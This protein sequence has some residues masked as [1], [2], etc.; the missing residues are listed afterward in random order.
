MAYHASHYVTLLLDQ[1]PKILSLI[2]DPFGWGWNLFG[3]TNK[4]R[5]AYLPDLTWVWHV[6]VTLI[7]AG[8]V[9]SVVLAHRVALRVFG[10]RREAILS[11]LPMLLLMVGF[12]VFGLWIL[13]QPLTAMVIR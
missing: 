13:A 8:H 12:T 2:S 6:Q 5:A 7:L 4:F 1:G 10:S 11:Q 9:S 3:T